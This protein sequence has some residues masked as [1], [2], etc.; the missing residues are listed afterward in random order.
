MYSSFTETMRARMLTYIEANNIK[1]ANNNT[2]PSWLYIN[3]KN[4]GDTNTN[5]Y[6]LSAAHASHSD[7]AWSVVYNGSIGSNYVY[8][9]A[10]C[11]LRPVI[12]LSK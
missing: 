5:G 8:D 7:F 12:T 3:L 4:T 9:E 1:T 11:G 2:M 6:W 10:Y